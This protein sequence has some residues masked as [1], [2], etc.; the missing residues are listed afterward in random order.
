MRFCLAVVCLSLFLAPPSAGQQPVDTAAAGKTDRHSRSLW[1]GLALTDVLGDADAPGRLIELG[2]EW[3]PWRF[4]GVG[5]VLGYGDIE[6]VGTCERDGLTVECRRFESI[7]SASLGATIYAYENPT[8]SAFGLAQIGVQSNGLGRFGEVGIGILFNAVGS[9]AV[10]VETR[11][12]FGWPDR[13]ASGEI[14][15]FR[16]VRALDR[17]DRSRGVGAPGS[18]TW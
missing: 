18:P 5:A 10:G 12:R 11:Q 4:L 2:I 16:V 6:E 7:Y 3:K 15:M 9:L 13:R 1:F 17:A 14:Y 8:L